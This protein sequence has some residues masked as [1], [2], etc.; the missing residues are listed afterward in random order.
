MQTSNRPQLTWNDGTRTLALTDS[1]GE[2]TEIIISAG[3]QDIFAAEN[4][5]TPGSGLIA[6]I[7]RSGN[8]GIGN[9]Q[10]QTDTVN[11]P[12]TFSST[13][14]GETI[15]ALHDLEA[16]GVAGIGYNPTG[17]QYVFHVHS[18]AV[19][20]VWKDSQNGLVMMSLDCGTALLNVNG[21]ITADR[22]VSVDGAPGVGG[23]L[24]VKEA[25]ANGTNKV[26]FRAPAAISSD[27][28]W[29][30]PSVDGTS[31][32]VLQ[33]NGSGVLSF[34]NAASLTV[35]DT[36]CIDLTLSS[37]TLLAT[38]IIAPAQDID[39]ATYGEQTFSNALSCTA[40]GLFVPCIQ[41]VEPTTTTGAGFTRF[42]IPCGAG[43]D[44]YDV[45]A[46]YETHRSPDEGAE[47]AV[48][49][50]VDPTQ[51]GLNFAYDCASGR[52]MFRN[53]LDQWE[54]VRGTCGFAGNLS[55]GGA[56]AYENIAHG[57]GTT[58]VVVSLRVGNDSY[59]GAWR[60]IDADTIAVQSA[61]SQVIRVAVLPVE[62]CS[63]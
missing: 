63:V 7:W 52:L 3:S 27:L 12:L 47:V 51:P 59:D 1:Y 20:F 4:S 43:Y 39:D 26:G 19:D 42:R 9:T 53:C 48:G 10:F 61:S 31:G 17:N 50:D 23:A 13:K 49:D 24:T 58:D 34:G 15:V 60:I 54:Y 21:Q 37:N 35:Q 22:E 46:F 38:P 57:L 5:S 25:T 30:L 36:N 56:G 33:T 62:Q 6:D 28:V 32:Q 55:H 45:P 29:T 44:E 11:Y 14:T 40:E 2:V 8:V 41:V 16:G 18:P